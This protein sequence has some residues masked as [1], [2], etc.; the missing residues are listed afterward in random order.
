MSS[1]PCPLTWETFI[2]DCIGTQPP[3]VFERVLAVLAPHRFESLLDD[4][5]EDEHSWREYRGSLWEL[6]PDEA[7]NEVAR[8]VRERL[9]LGP[10]I[11]ASASPGGLGL[12]EAIAAIQRAID[13]GTLHEPFPAWD[14]ARWTQVERYITCSRCGVT[15]LETPEVSDYHRLGRCP[16]KERW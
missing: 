5:N 3:G 14:G 2:E 12:G 10:T 9:T 8:I 6:L 13:R 1:P 11:L 16:L 15:Y 7:R 4:F